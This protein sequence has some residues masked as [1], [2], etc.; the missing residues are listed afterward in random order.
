MTL[1]EF[2]KVLETLEKNVDK[3]VEK[4]NKELDKT[5]QKDIEEDIVKRSIQEF[6][7]DYTPRGKK[8]P[9]KRKKDLFNAYRFSSKNGK[10]SLET[11]AK[12]MKK[13]HRAS[14][15]YIYNLAFVSGWHGGAINIEDSKIDEWGAHPD[16][17]EWTKG[18][19]P[20]TSGTPYWRTPP[21]PNEELGIDRWQFWGDSAEQSS[22]PLENIRIL[23]KEYER[24]K[25]KD[26]QKEA[27]KKGLSK[28]I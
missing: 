15:E 21:I 24:N 9:Y 20:I 23:L 3:A 17:G 27:I 7:D 22:S 16:P 11:G 13:K 26:R 14:H 12:F 25:M 6:Y 10:I 1:Q 19:D 18:D 28:L 4:I 5:Y 8:R 2:D